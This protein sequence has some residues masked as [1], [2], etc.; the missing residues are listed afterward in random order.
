MD[1][2][3][4]YIDLLIH[5]VLQLREGEALSVNTDGTHV[6]FAVDLAQT[7]SETTRQEVHVVVITAGKPTDVLSYTPIV[8]DRLASPPTRAVLLRIDDTEELPRMLTGNPSDMIKDLGALQRSGNLAPPQLNKPVAPW[9]VIAVPGPAWARHVLGSNADSQML[10]NHF[11]HVLGLDRSDHAQHWKEHLSLIRHRTATL[12]RLDPVELRIIGEGTDLTLRPVPESRWRDGITTLAD[13]R[14]FLPYIPPER[15]SMLADRFMTRGTITVAHPFSCLGR[16]IAQARFTFFEGK[17]IDFDASSGKEAL[18]TLLQADEGASRLSELSLVDR[19]NPL[20]WDLRRYGHLGFDENQGC[21]I[22]IG[23][24][25][26]SH[27]EALHTYADE[28]ELQRET[29]CNVSIVRGRIPFGGSDLSVIAMLS[30]GSETIIM[31]NGM[32][33]I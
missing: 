31:E 28:Q 26:A 32:F 10:W 14:A 15:V 5:L 6:D 18:G 20:A 27:L 2:R 11:G 22:V 17:V 13:G 24:G 1:I 30:D 19:N 23:T 21:S 9:A 29:G 16:E 7:A 8:H 12:N 3:E 25:G 4:R 33:N